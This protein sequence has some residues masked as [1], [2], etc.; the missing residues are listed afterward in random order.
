MAGR[1]SA[2]AGTMTT[3]R[4]QRGFRFSVFGFR[5]RPATTENPKPRTHAS[6][7]SY[8]VFP[9]PRR[10][11]IA[12]T[13]AALWALAPYA[14]AQDQPAFPDF[15]YA[16][17]KRVNE[18]D[19][20]QVADVER[21]E[22]RWK[23]IPTRYFR[24]HFAADEQEMAR[25]FAARADNLW[26]FLRARL[27]VEPAAPVAVFLPA[28]KEV[29]DRIR[30]EWRGTATSS[31]MGWSPDL[32]ALWCYPTPHYLTRFYWTMHCLHAIFE[33]VRMKKAEGE[34]G[35][36]SGWC[37]EALRQYYRLRV[38]DALRDRPA[39]ES[40]RAQAIYG[41]R[42]TGGW[43]EIGPLLNSTS[44]ASSAAGTA[45]AV[46]F[47]IEERFGTKTFDKLTRAMLDAKRG[48]YASTQDLFEKVLERPL[49]Q[50]EAEWRQFYPL[51][52][53]RPMVE[54]LP[55]VAAPLAVMAPAMAGVPMT[56]GSW[57]AKLSSAMA[58]CQSGQYDQALDTLDGLLESQ[59]A[60]MSGYEW[61]QAYLAAGYAYDRKGDRRRAMEQYALAGALAEPR[62]GPIVLWA[63]KGLVSPLTTP[64]FATSPVRMPMRAGLP[65]FAELPENH[66]ANLDQDGRTREADQQIQRLQAAPDGEDRWRA[67]EALGLLRDQRAVPHLLRFLNQRAEV[68]GY[69]QS[70][71]AA[72]ALGRIGDRAAVPALIEALTSV[73]PDTQRESLRA[74]QLITGQNLT[75]QEEWR[76]WLAANQRAQ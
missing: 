10:A 33:P 22:F 56:G 61:G 37:T 68:T 62:N 69:R 50:L 47:F 27:Q 23:M 45:C 46:W 25:Q 12:A 42:R 54:A 9:G 7:S 32:K 8:S 21:F 16:D 49:G 74:L 24:V 58:L 11:F 57:S 52:Q 64:P 15:S 63:E 39:G 55:A 41:L 28:T 75:T 35:E 20:G 3:Q 65:A 76:R 44:S 18:V 2:G 70:W 71:L 43:R 13:V 66:F 1:Q 14:I 26:L 30:A 31:S 6:C 36:W 17:L 38:W 4:S 73:N 29:Q 34:P 53:P 40:F 48:Q 5:R 19:W 67:I 72:K 51:D 59:G 60:A